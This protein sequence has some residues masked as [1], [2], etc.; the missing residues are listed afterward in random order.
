MEKCF[1]FWCEKQ[2]AISE[3][4]G[5]NTRTRV[6]HRFENRCT[7]IQYVRSVYHPECTKRLIIGIIRTVTESYESH[8]LLA[9]LRRQNGV[10]KKHSFFLPICIFLIL[11]SV[12]INNKD[13]LKT[14]LIFNFYAQFLVKTIRIITYCRTLM[15]IYGLIILKRSYLTLITHIY[16]NSRS[17]TRLIK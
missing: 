3:T 12:I 11:P 5:N 1:I 6:T 4:Y 13:L 10:V 7:C 8:R 9:D 16:I 17:R 14:R 15:P 2:S